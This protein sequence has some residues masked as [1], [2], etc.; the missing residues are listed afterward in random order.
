MW[1]FLT[2]C[3]QALSTWDRALI[4]EQGNN[5][6]QVLPKESVRF[7]W[8]LTG[9][10]VANDFDSMS[11]WKA[12]ISPES[13]PQHGRKLGKLHPCWS[14]LP[15]LQMSTLLSFLFPLLAIAFINLWKKLWIWRLFELHEP[16][17]FHSMNLS[18]SSLF[19]QGMFQLGGNSYTTAHSFLQLLFISAHSFMMLPESHMVKRVWFFFIHFQEFPFVM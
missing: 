8:L 5:S 11:D 7:L 4:K 2:K 18:P 17:N 19:Q 3:E 16:R 12:A 15:A 6:T 9:A 10:Q 14:S 1:L 13:P